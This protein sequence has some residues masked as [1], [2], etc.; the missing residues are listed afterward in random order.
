M[1]SLVMS[2]Y[3]CIRCAAVVEVGN[4]PCPAAPDGGPHEGVAPPNARPAG[5][6]LHVLACPRRAPFI[7]GDSIADAACICRQP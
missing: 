6:S 4:H 2:G 7:I 5:W 3:F 1:E